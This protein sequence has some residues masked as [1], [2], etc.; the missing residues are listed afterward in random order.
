MNTIY[1]ETVANEKLKNG[2]KYERLAAI[3]FKILSSDDT[4]IHDLKLKGDGKVASHQID[5]TI[6]KNHTKKRILIECK[7]YDN[8][9]GIDIIRDFFGA[10]YQ[11]QPDESF[12]VTTKGY[13]KPAVDFANDEKIKLF[14]L[15][16]FSESDWEDRIQNIEII[17][18]IRH[19]D[20]PVIKS[21][22]LSNSAEFQ[23]LTHKHKDLIGKKFSC[24]A[25]KTFFYDKDGHKTQS[26]N[27]VLQPIFNSLERIPGVTKTEE[28]LFDSS[29]FI[30]IGSSLVEVEGFEFEYSS[31][32]EIETTII[33]SSKKIAL[34][35]L[36]CLDGSI[37]ELLFKQ[38]IERWTF[39]DDGEVIMK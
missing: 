27:E 25:Y 15:R 16:A 14:V 6:E 31:Y 13:T 1:D 3:V 28:Y 33:D 36:K 37:N 24:N 35:V 30:Y 38:D 4:V 29:R 9:I 19:I 21:W 34:L 32:E 5:V 2:T 20:D 10:I 39:S 23:T 7:D 26:F 18:S 17:A 22:K 11:I 8:V 12:V